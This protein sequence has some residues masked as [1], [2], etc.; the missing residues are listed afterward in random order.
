MGP[1]GGDLCVWQWSAFPLLLLRYIDTANLGRWA[2]VRVG[3]GG[4]STRII[5][6]YQPCDPK[7]KTMGETV[8]DQHT[9]YFEALGEIRNPRVM[10]K[11]DLLNLLCAWIV[12]GDEVL[13][14]GNFN[15]DVY[16]GALAGDLARDEF[17]MTELCFCTTGIHPLSTHT[18]GWTPIDVVFAT[19]SLVCTAVTLLPSLVGIGD[20]RV[21][22]LDIDSRSLF[23]DVFPCVIPMSRRLLNCA[24]DWIKISYISVLNQPSNRHL[25][26]KK[27]LLIGK[28]S[29]SLS[30][31]SIHLRMN[32]VDLEL[33]HFMKS[34]EH[35]YHKYKL[36][37]IE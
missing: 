21:F 17:R 37:N 20:H 13:L 29:N 34:A 25:L 18:C 33:E 11:S 26:L 1:V 16:S 12:T 5:T 32:K 24:S 7:K 19:S 10:F 4:K 35:D 3:G 23:A 15:E 30:P 27:L 2:W 14:F 28:E 31:P 8:W 22:I 36:D 9:R 6:A